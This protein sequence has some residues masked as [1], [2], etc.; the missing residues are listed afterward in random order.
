MKLIILSFDYT[1][2]NVK[3]LAEEIGKWESIQMVS[4]QDQEELEV[5]QAKDVEYIVASDKPEIREKVFMNLKNQNMQIAT[6]I[7]PENYISE[8]TDIGAGCILYRGVIVY[9]DSVIGENTVMKEYSSLSHDSKLGEH[10]V[11]ME[12]CTI[13]GYSQI[14]NNVFFSAATVVKDELVIG[15]NVCTNSGAVVMKD[16]EPDQTVM[17]NPARIIR[18]ER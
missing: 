3:A 8:G 17:G 12:K 9:Y 4:C 16:I 6:L 15:N 14:G 10:C 11:I 7:H 5:S 2:K 1:G 13:G 18:K